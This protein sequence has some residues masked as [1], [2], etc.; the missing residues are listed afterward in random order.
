MSDRRSFLCGL[1]SL[2]LIGGGISLIGNPTKAAVPV[3]DDLLKRYVAFLAHEH[4]AALFE[5]E[6]VR[7]SPSRNRRASDVPMLWLPDDARAQSLCEHIAP[8][9]R[10]AVVLSA[11]GLPIWREGHHG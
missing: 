4:R 3:S 5:F 6:T 7:D 11:V 9:T 8:S 2:P 10:A 1:A